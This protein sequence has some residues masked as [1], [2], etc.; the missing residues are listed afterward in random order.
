M[1]HHSTHHEHLFCS[2]LPTAHSLS[3]TLD[4]LHFAQMITLE[5]LTSLELTITEVTHSWFTYTNDPRGLFVPVLYWLTR[6]VKTLNR[7]NWN[8]HL[9]YLLF[10]SSTNLEYSIYLGTNPRI[11]N[12]PKNWVL[13]PPKNSRDSSAVFSLS[14]GH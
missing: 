2:L 14:M 13:N 10:L 1:S 3:L 8:D 11:F 9:S 6:S 12:I 7:S 5:S 4:A